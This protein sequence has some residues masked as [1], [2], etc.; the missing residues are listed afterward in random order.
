MLFAF[1]GT[2]SFWPGGKIKQQKQ[3]VF[4]AVK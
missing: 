4:T 1:S 3:K 2:E